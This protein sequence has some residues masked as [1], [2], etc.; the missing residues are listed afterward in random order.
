MDAHPSQPDAAPTRAAERAVELIADI[1]EACPER[2]PCSEGERRAQ[3][4]LAA[5]LEAAGASAELRPMRSDTH[6]YALMGLHFGLSLL[7]TAA[8]FWRPEVAFALHLLVAASYYGDSTRRWY[9]LRRLLPRRDSQNLVATLPA[10]GPVRHRLV[11]MAHAD[12][13]Y[14]GFTFQPWLLAAGVRST[15]PGLSYLSRALLVATV[16]ITMLAAVDAAAW[17]EGGAGWSLGWLAAI[18]SFPSLVGFVLN[19]EVVLRDRI[20]PGANDN[21]TGCA[22]AL[23]MARRFAADPPPEGAEVVLVVTGCEEAGTR[24]AYELARRVRGSEWPAAET[25]ILGVDGL[26]NGEIRW[27]EEGEISTVPVPGWLEEVLE[28]AAASDQRFE[29]ARRFHIPLGATDAL[30]FLAAG[31]DAVSI[32]CVDPAVGAPGHYH[33]PSDTAENLDPEKLDL[34]LDFVERVAR[35]ILAARLPE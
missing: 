1:I 31:Y 6:L 4:M 21:L 14:T 17:L 10:R 25:T 20:V 9:L 29:E 8:L 3:E 28:E 33:L 13:A 26:S 7:A 23:E 5:E 11:L 2:A 34:A 27:F 35:G 22:G 24:G 16:S 18:L 12:A 30:P 19:A 15:L 32:G